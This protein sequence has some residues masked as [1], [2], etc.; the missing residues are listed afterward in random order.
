MATASSHANDP[1]WA[2]FFDRCLIIDLETRADGSIR[3]L[4]A[5]RGASQLK[6]GDFT[7][8]DEA[9]QRLNAFGEGADLVVGHNIVAH[10]RPLVEA[11]LSGSALLDLPVVD[12]LYLAPLAKPQNPYHPLV[13][14]YKRVRAEQSD[15]VADCLLTR[16]LLKDC[17]RL[18]L[19]W[20]SRKPGLLS[21]YRTC[22]DDSDSDKGEVASE[23]RLD[24]PGLFLEALGGRRLTHSR[25]VNGFHHFTSDR[26]CPAAVSRHL[27]RLLDQPDA[28]PAVA[29]SLA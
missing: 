7:S 26:A 25:L 9:V 19:G 8:P 15:P 6:I 2:R 14:D 3:L 12:T 10:D 28:R 22:F 29:Y 4:G 17:W 23:L 5:V 20:K 24:G 11:H 21:F 16:K 13:K 27:P 1:A 18:F